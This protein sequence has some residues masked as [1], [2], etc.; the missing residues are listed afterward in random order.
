MFAKLFTFIAASTMFLGSI[1][2]SLSRSS[3][4]FDNWRG[5]SSLSG[6]DA[7]YGSDDFS[8]SFYNTIIIEQQQEVVC[9]SE[10]IEIIQQRLLVL[11]ET[12]KRII[13]EQICEV[14]TQTIVFQQFHASISSF[15]SDLSRKSGRSVGY[16]SG[17]SSHYGDLVS[18]NGSLSNHDLGF[19]G[20]D[21]GRQYINVHG[22]NWNWM[23]SPAS[24]GAAQSAAQRAAKS[25]SNP[26]SHIS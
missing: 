9:H 15:S 16:D 12:A 4:S 2:T 17:I 7:F 24:V 26:S 20:H 8:G 19:S 3:S 25:S 5:I 23:S 1:S 21:L 11:Q 13:T 10:S 14:E 18:S 22:S 6:F